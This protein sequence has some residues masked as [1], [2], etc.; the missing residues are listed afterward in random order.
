MEATSWSFGPRRRSHRKAIAIG[1]TFAIAAF[2]LV[3]AAQWLTTG[4]GNGYSKAGSLQSLVIVDQSFTDIPATLFPGGNGSLSIKVTNPNSG[5]V[6]IT[7]VSGNS[8]ISSSNESNCSQS[9]I[10]FTDQTGLSLGPV[11]AGGTTVLSVPG[12]HM[13]ANASTLCQGV[14][15]TIPVLVTG[16]L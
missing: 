11:P 2:T 9:N 14:T 10:T 3:A 13:D 6:T 4:S 15:F 8:S 5:P 16:A 7:S 1:A 12:V